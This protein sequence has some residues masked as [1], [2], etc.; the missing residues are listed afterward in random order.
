[1]SAIFL[2]NSVINSELQSSDLSIP[3]YN[4]ICSARI[5][6]SDKKKVMQSLRGKF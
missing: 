4:K 3:N 5:I 6:I 1:M 2:R